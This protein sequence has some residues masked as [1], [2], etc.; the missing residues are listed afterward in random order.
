MAQKFAHSCSAALQRCLQ[1]E[2]AMPHLRMLRRNE[3]FSKCAVTSILQ[4]KP[5]MLLYLIMIR[6]R[7]AR[8]RPAPPGCRQLSLSAVHRG[9]HKLTSS[10]N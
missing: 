10:L 5:P 1:N 3:N 6:A 7:L 4:L 9:A 2:G 8:A